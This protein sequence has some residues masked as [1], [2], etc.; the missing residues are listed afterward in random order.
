MLS[1]QQAARFDEMLTPLY[2]APVSS[3]HDTVL[4]Y[5]ALSEEAMGWLAYMNRKVELDGTWAKDGKPHEAWDNVSGAPVQNLYRYDLTYGSFAV[6]MMAE[7]TP[8]WREGYS[9]IL[10][11][12]VDRYFEYWAFCDW[13]EEKGQD[14][15]RLDYPEVMYKNLMPEGYAGRYSKP[16][17]AANGIGPYG[18]N[19]DPVYGNGMANIMYK[20][21]LNLSIGLYEYVSGDA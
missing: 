3:L 4:G 20:G 19:P 1:N 15:G 9:K 14:P 21:Y 7:L 2:P 10:S 16:G 6:A 5:P 12:L 18:Y 17:W 13:V 8:A 11:F